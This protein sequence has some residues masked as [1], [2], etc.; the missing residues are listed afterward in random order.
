MSKQLFNSAMVGAIP[1]FHGH[2]SQTGPM[3]KAFCEMLKVRIPDEHTEAVVFSAK[4]MFST[5][6]TWM[7][8]K[9]AMDGS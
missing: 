5:F 9:S 8:G 6:G 3:W 4:A 2:G 7:Q 1:Y